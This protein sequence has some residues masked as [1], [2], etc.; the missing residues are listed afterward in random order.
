MHGLIQIE[1]AAPQHAQRD[2]PSLLA[3]ECD[4][5]QEST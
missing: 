1:R 2:C 5:R 4:K 3:Q